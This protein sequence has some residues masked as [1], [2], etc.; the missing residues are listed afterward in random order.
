MLHGSIAGATAAIFQIDLLCIRV[1]IGKI[2]RRTLLD[3]PDR[4]KGLENDAFVPA[5]D[6]CRIAT[7]RRIRQ[8]TQLILGFSDGTGIHG[9]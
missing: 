4:L 1:A 8:F 9:L 2:A 3:C 5:R 7:Q 6:D